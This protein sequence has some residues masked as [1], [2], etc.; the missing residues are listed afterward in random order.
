MKQF[1]LLI[2]V[3]AFTGSFAQQEEF[4]LQGQV[5]DANKNPVG[6][7][8]IFNERSTRRYVSGNNGIFDVWVLPGDSVIITHIS[9]IRKAVTVHQLMINPIVQLELDTINIRPVNVSASQRSDYEKAMKNIERIEFDFRPNSNDVSTETERMQSLMQQEDQVQRV[10][11]SSVRLAGFSPSEEINKI[12]AK[13]RKKKE[14]K[15]FSSTKESE[16]DKDK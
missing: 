6:D 14:A 16:P 5:V 7:A 13:H 2:L 9:F 1:L 15:Q 12:L 11:A 4:H 3:F 8:L 10:A